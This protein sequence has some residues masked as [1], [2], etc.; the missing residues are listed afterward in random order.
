MKYG[1][2]GTAAVAL[3]LAWPAAVGQAAMTME[4]LET[5]IKILQQ[6]V[7]ELKAM[8]LQAAPSAPD[9]AQA[10]SR[11]TQPYSALATEERSPVGRAFKQL[12]G[13]TVGGYLTEQLENFEGTNRTFNNQ[14]FILFVGREVTDRLRFYSEVEFE[15]LASIEADPADSR[16][17]ALEVEQAW[18]DYG[19]NDLVNVRFGNVLVPFGRF[20]LTHDDPLQE[21]TSRPLVDRRVVPTTWTETGL[22]LYGSWNPSG[23]WNVSYETYVVNGLNDHISSAAGGLRDARGSFGIDNNNDKALVGRI[24]V[25]PMPAV[26]IGVAGYTGEYDKQGHRANGAAIDWRA[27]HGPFE[28]V[29]DA[30]LFDLARGVNN[31]GSVVPD[32]LWGAYVEGRYRFWPQWLNGTFLARGFDD[33][34]LTATLRYDHAAIGRFA[35]AGDFSEDRFTIGLN[36]RPA[37]VFVVKLDYEINNGNIERG[38]AN[39]FIASAAL[40][41]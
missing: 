14:R 26:E 19:I 18:I 6:Q 30:A 40:S 35:G 21:L 36:Y 11:F 25:S 22:G 24:A 23:D 34:H 33:P 8:Q 16:G 9:V 12:T 4:Q 7:A 41:F 39:G 3:L 1:T 20:N 31:S 10:P 32:R 29:G 38:G 2:A 15:Q 27:Q 13:A 17:G 28:M 37:D 5:Q